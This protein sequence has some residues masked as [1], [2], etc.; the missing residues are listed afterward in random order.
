MDVAEQNYEMLVHTF[1]Y[2]RKAVNKMIVD[3]FYIETVVHLP[4]SEVD[5]GL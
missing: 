2:Y 4:S 3:R 5:R 1:G